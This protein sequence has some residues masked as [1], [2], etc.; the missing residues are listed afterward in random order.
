M[1]GSNSHEEGL[2]R[3]MANPRT[4]ETISLL[5]DADRPLHVTDLAEQFV[6]QNTAI[7]DASDYEEKYE[8]MLMVLHHNHLPKLDDAGLADYD[9]DEN[10]V[11]YHG[12]S[13][14]DVE[15]LDCDPVADII[16]HFETEG[17]VGED[18]IGVLK[19]RESVIKH[20]QW[21]A[22]EAN[23][24]LFCMYVSDE[25]LGEECVRHAENAIIRGVNIYMGSQNSTVRE[26]TRKHLPEAT[27]WE[28]QLD[29]MSRSSD[30]PT[31]G[32]LVFADRT[33]LMLALVGGPDTGEASE[34]TA[35][36]AEGETNPFVVFV[37]ELLGPRLDHLDHQ[38]SNFR[39]ALE[40]EP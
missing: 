36:I 11:T 33:K 38:S 29:W 24:E 5:R 6:D 28:P 40:F 27:L 23:E 20:G 13:T 14:V 21:L 30:T 7:V 26:L 17:E 10:I 39:S 25:L 34:E 4:R 32:R 3:L 31:I 8:R 15:W 1:E 18:T 35:L 37:R 12:E 19:G 22:D 16:E 2:I 9:R